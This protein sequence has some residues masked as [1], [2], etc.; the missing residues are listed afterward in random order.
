[1]YCEAFRISIAKRRN[2]LLVLGSKA[3]FVVDDRKA[4]KGKS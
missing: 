2:L 3:G 1:M 4:Q